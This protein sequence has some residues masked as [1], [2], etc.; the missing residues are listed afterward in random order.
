M[1]VKF[2]EIE[3]NLA[4]NQLHIKQ[5]NP[6]WDCEVIRCVNQNTTKKKHLKKERESDKTAEKK[7]RIAPNNTKTI[8]SFFDSFCENKTLEHHLNGNT[9][10]IDISIWIKS[11]YPPDWV[12][13]NRRERK[14]LI[15]RRGLSNLCC[16]CSH[17]C[18]IQKEGAE[19]TRRWTRR[20]VRR[21]ILRS[22]GNNNNN[23]ETIFQ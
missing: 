6:L 3:T 11:I 10:R 16:I 9:Q 13:K 23:K 17:S 8:A 4:G 5:Y 20:Q 14:V 2:I 7:K 21:R 18:G 15:N 22:K 12:E 1:S 19:W